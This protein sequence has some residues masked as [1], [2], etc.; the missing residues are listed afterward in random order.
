LTRRTS[1]QNKKEEEF[2]SQKEA[3]RGVKERDEEM[4]QLGR[5]GNKMIT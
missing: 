4:G 2:A 3:W 5:S 1:S